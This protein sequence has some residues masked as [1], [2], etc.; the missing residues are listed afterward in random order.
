M[1]RTTALPGLMPFQD[2][3]E[4]QST[5]GV[6]ASDLAYALK[7]DSRT[8]ERWSSGKSYPQH[9]AR[10]QLAILRSI[11]RH[12]RATFTDPETARDWFHSPQRYLGWLSPIEV[13]RAG[14]FDRI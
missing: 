7:V 13:M 9:Q 3:E 14:R 8:V 6:S 12:V 10:Q 5:L 4:L 2:F 1:A 11:F